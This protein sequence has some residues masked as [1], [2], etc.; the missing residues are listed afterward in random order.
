MTTT[1]KQLRRKHRKSPKARRQGPHPSHASG[2]E[3][4]RVLEPAY[5]AWRSLTVPHNQASA[6]WAGLLA[7]LE[8]Y[9]AFAPFNSPDQLAPQSF[10][11]M[12]NGIRRMP[13]PAA[14]DLLD[15]L[16]SYLHFLKDNGRWHRGS[17]VFDVLHML[18]LIRVPGR[19]NRTTPR[20]CPIGTDLPHGHGIALV[21][22]AAYLLDRMLEGKF[23]PNS[24]DSLALPVAD[25]AGTKLLAPGLYPLPVSRFLE[26]FESMRVADLYETFED[27]HED[28]EDEDDEECWEN[29]GEPYPTHSGMAL[30]QDEHPRNR[31]AVRSL[32]AAY[33]KSVIWAIARPVAGLAGLRRADECLAVLVEVGDQSSEAK[34]RGDTSVLTLGEDIQDQLADR[35]GEI[36]TSILACLQTGV[37]EYS[38]GSLIA[39]PMVREAIKELDDEYNKHRR[40]AALRGLGGGGRASWPGLAGS[41]R[42]S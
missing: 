4:L 40:P 10:A 21:Q 30:L 18:V 15:Q 34:A 2:L 33:L 13:G 25:R 23:S 32:L 1:S 31:E 9:A 20:E 19:A 36:S 38:H 28:S 7:V 5:L 12:L 14:C 39:Q 26:V 27:E 24:T 11:S 6:D 8:T 17:E 42:P 22:W 35:Y 3:R 37:L 41:G 16:D 29:Y